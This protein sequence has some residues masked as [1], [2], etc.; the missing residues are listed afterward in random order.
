MLAIGRA[1]V[2]WLIAVGYLRGDIPIIAR[3]EPIQC[4]YIAGTGYCVGAHLVAWRLTASIAVRVLVSCVLIAN[5]VVQV[6]IADLHNSRATTG[7]RG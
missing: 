7:F 1:C 5:R 2:C 6:G 3:A 4:V